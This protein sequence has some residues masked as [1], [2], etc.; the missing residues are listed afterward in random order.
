[1]TRRMFK[2]VNNIYRFDVCDGIC[3]TNKSVFYYHFGGGYGYGVGIRWGTDGGYGD[4]TPLT[5]YIKGASASYIL[6]ISY[7]LAFIPDEICMDAVHA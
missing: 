3:H 2:D 4:G 7:E 6:I 1:M 5:C